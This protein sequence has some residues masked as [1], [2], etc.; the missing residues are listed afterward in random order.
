M[1]TA[2]LHTALTAAKAL[3]QGWVVIGVHAHEPS[4]PSLTLLV[5]AY[6]GDREEAVCSCGLL[7]PAND[8]NN[9]GVFDV[10][11]FDRPRGRLRRL[12][13]EPV[14]TFEQVDPVDRVVVFPAAVGLT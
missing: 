8:V 11:G 5:L 12:F 2:S 3:I 6:Q 13:D 4:Q 10:E 1:P 7:R 14:A 9:L